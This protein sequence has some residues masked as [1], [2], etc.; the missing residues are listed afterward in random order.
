MPIR[1]VVTAGATETQ[2]RD[3]GSKAMQIHDLRTMA[4]NQF[5]RDEGETSGGERPARGFRVRRFDAP[6]PVRSKH[7]SLDPIAEL[8]DPADD[9]GDEPARFPVRGDGAVDADPATYRTDPLL[10]TQAAQL[11]DYIRTRQADLARRQ[12]QL[13]AQREHFE[14][15]R[16]E[17]ERTRRELRADVARTTAEFETQNASDEA[18]QLLLEQLEQQRCHAANPS[19]SAAPTSAPVVSREGRADAV[20]MPAGSAQRVDASRSSKNDAVS[21]WSAAPPIGANGPSERAAHRS[22]SSASAPSRGSEPISP[23][24]TTAAP[25]PAPAPPST[26]G[27]P[28]DWNVRLAE[29]ERREAEVARRSAAT[30]HLLAEA[31]QRHQEALELRIVTEQLWGQLAG[32]MVPDD[33]TRSLRQLR[34]K[35]DAHYRQA[36]EELDDQQDHVAELVERLDQQQQHLR[37]QRR[38]LQAWVDRRH[39]ELEQAHGQLLARQQEVERGQRQL[40]ALRAAM[41][42]EAREYQRQ[43]RQLTA[44]LRCRDELGRVA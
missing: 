8:D 21:P 36:R 5:R 37:R 39:E 16:D 17:F 34:S 40:E 25:A 7:A 19:R 38:D 31:R 13:D 30:E 44:Q 42:E 9:L 28:P 4:G 35:L 11:V 3:L 23:S 14:Q 10:A 22:A 27:L 20:A 41:D 32:R 6:H 18:I 43:I 15:A 24:S 26:E 2:F 33:L 12:E 1:K 29:L